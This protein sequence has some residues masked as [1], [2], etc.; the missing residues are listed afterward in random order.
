MRFPS[1]GCLR[2]VPSLKLLVG[3][4][5]PFSLGVYFDVQSEQ[6]CAKISLRWRFWFEF[7][8]PNLSS[9]LGPASPVC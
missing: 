7:V 4:K 8:M 6:L 3:R 1:L 2:F 9:E 5:F